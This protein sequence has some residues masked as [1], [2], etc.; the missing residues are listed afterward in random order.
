MAADSGGTSATRP[1]RVGW[2]VDV[3]AD[4]MDP[5]GRLYVRD[6][7]DDSDPGAVRIV[8]ALERVTAWMS[9]HCDV[10]VYTGDWHGLEDA[11]IDPVAPDPGRDTYP[12]HC[13]GRSP[14]QDERAGAEVIAEIRPV[15]PVVLAHDAGEEEARSAAR[16]AVAERRP[17]FVRKTRFN[18]FEG[19]PGADAFVRSLGDALG[20]RPEFVVIGVA[21]DVCVT[22]AVDGLLERGR[23]VTAVRDAT[24]GLGLEP[25]EVTL[26]RWAEGGRVVTVA[27]LVGGQSHARRRCIDPKCKENITQ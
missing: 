23:E 19:N 4:F 15:D 20:R 5:A 7:F 26:A 16:R 6:L 3:Q 24:W 11:E 2:I 27:E 18:V 14:D 1:A 10:V 22:Q 25:E 17:V 8:P 21:R 12:P 9:E 13:M